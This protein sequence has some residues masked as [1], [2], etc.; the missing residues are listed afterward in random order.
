MN[1]QRVAELLERVR[2][3]E[4]GL[5]RKPDPALTATFLMAMVSG[6]FVHA[7]PALR[8]DLKTALF[9]IPEVNA[10]VGDKAINH[11]IRMG[12]GSMLVGLGQLA[13]W[14]IGKTLMG[15]EVERVAASL[16]T[17]IDNA[18]EAFIIAPL[19]GIQV[20][21]TERIEEGIH[22][23]PIHELPTPMRGSLSSHMPKQGPHGPGPQAALVHTFL[24]K[25][26]FAPMEPMEDGAGDVENL[27]SIA[28]ALHQQTERMKEAGILLTLSGL[29]PVHPLGAWY[30]HAELTPMGDGYSTMTGYRIESYQA[31]PFNFMKP[32]SLLVNLDDA[33]IIIREF[34]AM[35]EGQRQRLWISIERLNRS[36]RRHSPV[37]RAIELGIALESLLTKKKENGITHVM[38]L[39][40]ALFLGGTL[41]ERER[42]RD[43]VRTAYKLRSSAVH[44]GKL[45]DEE[46]AK[47]NLEAASLICSQIIRKILNHGKFPDWNKLELERGELAT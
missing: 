21:S 28:A 31:D 34:R 30:S 32:P 20:N 37:D 5:S 44:E 9:S 35:E 8:D 46:A 16:Q 22:L 23:M 39:R 40:S 42:T 43:A 17:I 18:A 6:Q 12:G 2:N 15:Y 33:R 19:D 13:D 47:G 45:R 26:L 3:G 25:P 10:I 36:L 1:I 14:L 38:G 41:Q 27:S 24:Q 4:A 11:G 7:S 29:R